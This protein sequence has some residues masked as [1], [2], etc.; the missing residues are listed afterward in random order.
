[1]ETAGSRCQAGVNEKTRSRTRKRTT[2][3]QY[4]TRTKRIQQKDK[5]LRRASSRVRLE[6][7][8]ED[9]TRRRR[10][11]QEDKVW[12]P[13]GSSGQAAHQE[14]ASFFFPKREPQ[15]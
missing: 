15:Q 8:Q 13:A 7:G 14:K 5:D 12:R 9:G 10:Q 3:G 4:K 1:M 6:E 11:T 2:G